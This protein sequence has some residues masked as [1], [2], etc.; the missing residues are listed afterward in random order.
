MSNKILPKFLTL[1]QSDLK[2]FKS[3]GLSGR[4]AVI[5][6]YGNE[7]LE[8]LAKHFDLTVSELRTKLN[9]A[10]NDLD[11]QD[12]K[13]EHKKKSHIEHSKEDEEEEKERRKIH[14]FRKPTDHDK[15]KVKT[16]IENPRPIE[17]KGKGH[18]N[19][20]DRK[21]PP[22]PPPNPP[23]LPPLTIDDVTII[24]TYKIKK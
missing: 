9:Q 7:E 23:K 6:S 19:H 18:I 24:A 22:P 10:A 12:I 3:I 15:E 13:V 1:I 14:K 2:E 20:T 8:D 5:D 21:N 17:H 16:R 11:R 4:Y